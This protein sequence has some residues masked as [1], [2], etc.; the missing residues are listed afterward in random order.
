MSNDY[1]LIYFPNSHTHFPHC[2]N[3][4]ST[5]DLF[6][7]KGFPF[8]QSIFTDHSLLSDHVPVI[9][10]INFAPDISPNNDQFW[11]KDYS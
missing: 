10:D 8:P 4:P 2:G 11:I 6:L 3:L 1:F 9:C 5:I 7:S